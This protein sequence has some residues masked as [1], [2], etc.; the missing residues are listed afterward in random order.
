MLKRKEWSQ[1][2]SFNSPNPSIN[3]HIV[4]KLTGRIS[5]ETIPTAQTVATLAVAAATVASSQPI[6]NPIQRNIGQRIDTNQRRCSLH[7]TNQ[8]QHALENSGKFHRFRPFNQGPQAA[9]ATIGTLLRC[10]ISI[11]PH[12][13]SLANKSVNGLIESNII[14]KR[15]NVA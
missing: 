9:L 15:I 1:H 13:I 8:A 4:P 14:L 2:R 10:H 12:P 3:Q 7:S 5:P 11:H 6:R